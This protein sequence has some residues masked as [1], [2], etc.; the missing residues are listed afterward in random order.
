M[1]GRTAGSDARRYRALRFRELGLTAQIIMQACNVKYARAY[2]LIH[3]TAILSKR[4]LVALYERHPY[5]TLLLVRY[6]GL[7]HDDVRVVALREAASRCGCIE[8]K[9]SLPGEQ[10]TLTAQRVRSY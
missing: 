1:T 8:C 3:G 6:L 10:L 7:A 2:R 5:T 9:A 4:E